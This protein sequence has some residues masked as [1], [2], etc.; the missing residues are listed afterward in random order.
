MKSKKTLQESEVLRM[1]EVLTKRL[2]YAPTMRELG[3]ALGKTGSR[4]HQIIDVLVARGS[5]ERKEH[6]GR[7][8][9]VVK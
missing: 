3:E 1:I 7:T 2:G 8:L 4:V 9:K 5:L 6:A